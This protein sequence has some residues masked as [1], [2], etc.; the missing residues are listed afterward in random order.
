MTE[1]GKIVRWNEERGLIC[2]PEEVV[3]ENEMSYIVEEVIEAMTHLKS[4]EARPHARAICKAIRSG[5]LKMISDFID[6]NNLTEEQP[7]GDAIAELTG[8]QIADACGDI[9]V[10]ATGTIRKVGYNPDIVQ[11]EVQREIDSRTGKIIDGKFT[12]D[13][14]DEAQSRWYKANFSK[15]VIK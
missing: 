12:K 10:F 15:A 8:E 7:N 2:K 11:A 13:M 6:S 5:N 4:K 14:S 1:S 9:K 3:I